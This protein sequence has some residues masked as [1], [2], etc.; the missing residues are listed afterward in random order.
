MEKCATCDGTGEVHS[1]NPRCWDCQGKGFIPVN[2]NTR[3]TS[4]LVPR[5]TGRRGGSDEP[6]LIGWRETPAVS[7][8]LVKGSGGIT[9]V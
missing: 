7:A 8:A 9:P 2:K 4:E 5:P 1:H 3:S 6:Q